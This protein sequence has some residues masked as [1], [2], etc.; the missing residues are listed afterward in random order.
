MRHW[1]ASEAVAAVAAA[2]EEEVAVGTVVGIDEVAA[3][4]G[5]GVEWPAEVA[6][7]VAGCGTPAATVAG[8]IAA[9]VV[10]EELAV[11]GI[12]VVSEEGT[13]NRGM[14]AH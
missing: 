6:V 9:V 2:G 4:A 8:R 14:L 7:R 13:V 10:G 11:A 5:K 1:T 12:A 3:W